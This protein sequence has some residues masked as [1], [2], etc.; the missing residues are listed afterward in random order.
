[1][2][3]E[4]DNVKSTIHSQ[5]QC[6]EPIIY[7]SL[8]SAHNTVLVTCLKTAKSNGFLSLIWL[9]HFCVSSSLMRDNILLKWTL[10]PSAE[11]ASTHNGNTG[12]GRWLEASLE[13]PCFRILVILSTASIVSFLH[14]IVTTLRVW[15]NRQNA[16]NCSLLDLS[17]SYSSFRR[18]TTQGELNDLL[19][20]LTS[21]QCGSELGIWLIFVWACATSRSCCAGVIQHA[22]RI[23]SERRCAILR[24]DR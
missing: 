12:G 20:L 17:L 9:M 7:T 14:I 8:P 2:D 15:C 16:A 18:L 6:T 22:C 5:T 1:M 11:Q 21:C 23:D 3:N 4:Q 13:T 24:H 10:M 19:S